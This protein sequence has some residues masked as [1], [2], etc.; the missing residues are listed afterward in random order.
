M[1]QH[2]GGLTSKP[3]YLRQWLRDGRCATDLV[4]VTDSYDV[5]FAA[6][7]NE[8]EKAYRKFW[9]FQPIVFNAEKNLFPRVDL[10]DHFPDMGTPWRYL[11][12]G[13]MIGSPV[14]IL[15]LLDGMLLD[16]IHEDYRLPDGR[17]VHPNDQGWFQVAY[18]LQVTP[19]RIDSNCHI[20]QTFSAC[21]LDEFEIGPQWRTIRNK[22]TGTEPLVLHLNGGAKNDIMPALM[23]HYGL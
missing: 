13:L 21:T 20:F 4:I 10:A 19:T 8:V 11:N 15:K 18:A 12:S 23:Q 9:S 22:F 7:P 17:W 14:D 1:G 6:P 5:I 16:D 3:R 2:W